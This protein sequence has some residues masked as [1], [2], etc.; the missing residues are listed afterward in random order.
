ML[1]AKYSGCGTPW[2]SG[3]QGRHPDG[4]VDGGTA[5]DQVT[6]DEDGR[7]AD[8]HGGEDTGIAPGSPAERGAEQRVL[9]LDGG[10]EAEK[11]PGEQAADGVH[12]LDSKQCGYA[13]GHG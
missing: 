11:Y 2:A 12:S 5:G 13:G 6:G 7:G 3:R 4:G 9:C 1:Q 10:G 8:G